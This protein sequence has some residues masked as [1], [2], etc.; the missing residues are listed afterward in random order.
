MPGQIAAGF[1]R[2]D[3]GIEY[4]RGRRTQQALL[5]HARWRDGQAE[6]GGVPER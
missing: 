6:A 4:H 3:K 1:S 5:E 2:G